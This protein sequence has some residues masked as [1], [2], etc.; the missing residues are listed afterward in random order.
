M[1]RYL[2]VAAVVVMVG[3][4]AEGTFAQQRM[5]GTTTNQGFQVGGSTGAGQGEQGNFGVGTAGQVDT[6]ARYMR[7]NRQGNFVGSDS[8][9]TSF[10]GAATSG[11]TGR[12]NRNIRRGGG[13]AANVNQG[14]GRGRQQNEVRIVLQLGFTPP[15][16]GSF[17]PQRAPKAV[18]AKLAD[19]MNRSSWIQNRSQMEVTID[20]G[21]ATLQGV[22]STEHDR[23]LAERLAMLEG[24]IRKVENLLKVESA[25]SGSGEAPGLLAP[26]P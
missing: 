12:S 4:F 5:G 26:T 3:S 1:R 16:P 24:G 19:R 23:V 14:R 8:S 10:V 17:A 7:D 13:G 18:A 22:V 11:D 2:I 15:K 6:N 9:D 21:V 25:S 20:E